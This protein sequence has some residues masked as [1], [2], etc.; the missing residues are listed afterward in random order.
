MTR[1]HVAIVDDEEDLRTAVSRYLDRQGFD[2]SEAG[3]GDEL[4]ALLAVRAADLVLL[5]VNMP[6]EDGLSILR[7]LR[8]QGDVPILMVT[9][10]ADCVD[11]VAGLEA[12]ADDYIAK[13][14]DLRELLARIRAVLRRSGNPGTATASETGTTIRMGAF[15]FDLVARSLRATDGREVSLTA[16][17]AELLHL[18]A[19]RA[20]HVITRDDILDL[21][22]DPDAEPFSRAIDMRIGR[23]RKKIE[24]DPNRPSVIRTVHGQGYM[25]APEG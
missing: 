9:G 4:R 20:G 24:R 10:A 5:D 22:D 8:R 18:L 19:S 1:T 2:V 12:G 6:R 7:F 21:T 16:Q 11:R 23:L 3:S 15:S 17:E 14:F 25:L 13:P